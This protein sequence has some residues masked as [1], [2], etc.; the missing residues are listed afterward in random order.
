MLSISDFEFIFAGHGHYKVRYK[1]PLRRTKY[2]VVT[3]NMPLIDA[4]KNAENPTQKDLQTLRRLCRSG[5]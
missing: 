3:D 5:A 2:D 1:T 4:T